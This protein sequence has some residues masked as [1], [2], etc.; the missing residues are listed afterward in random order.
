MYYIGTSGWNY[1][2][3][4]GKFYP[5][6]M[7]QDKYLDYYCRQFNTVELNYSFYRLPSKRLCQ[8]WSERTTN[9]FVF[10]LKAGRF[11]THTK[12]L[13]DAKGYFKKFYQTAAFLGKKLGP[14]LFQLPPSLQRDAQRLDKFLT[15]L[16]SGF[17]N[18][19]AAFE[20]R[21]KSWHTKEVYKL[22]EKYEIALVVAD[23]GGR[24][25][26]ADLVRTANFL[27]FRFHGPKELFASKYS[28]QELAGW[29]ERIAKFAGGKISTYIYFNNDFNAYAVDNAKT[30]RSFLEHR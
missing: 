9:E 18:I 4:R 20:F 19:D 29:A 15:M 25:P 24:Y 27:Y 1:S 12:R 16:R 5:E 28:V 13:K 14:I 23:S 7:N 3:W 10:S 2:S 21:H 30:M 6:K 26:T 17:E 8:G 11:I 22:L